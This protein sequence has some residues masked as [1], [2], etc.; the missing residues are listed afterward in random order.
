M[1]WTADSE[2][3]VLDT[4]VSN[5]L[6]SVP[7]FYIDV[8]LTLSISYPLSTDSILFNA[9]RQIIKWDCFYSRWRIPKP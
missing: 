2:T 9:D 1:T 7:S 8:V 6:F 4:D 5:M 3:L